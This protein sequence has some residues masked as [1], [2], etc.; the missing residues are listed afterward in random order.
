MIDILRQF[1]LFAKLSDSKLQWWAEHGEESWLE[2]G[3]ILFK[4]GDPAETMFFFVL[5]EGELQ[6]TKQIGGSEVMITYQPG[7]FTGE[8]PILTGKPCGSTVRAVHPS[9]VLQI[10]AE[11]FK[12]LML[13]CS[14]MRDIILPTMMQRLQD[15]EAMLWQRE[16]MAALG[17]LSAG[18]AHELNNPA[19]AGRRAAEQLYETVQSL[20]SLAL[21]L[22]AQAGASVPLD[23][24]TELQQEALQRANTSLRLDPLAQSD[25]EEECSDWLSSSGIQNGWRLAPTLVRAGLNTTWLDSLAARIA[26]Q[27]SNPAPTLHCVLAWLEA[28]LSTVSLLQEIEQSTSRISN[29]VSAVKSYSYMDQASVQEIDVH[30]GLESTMIVLGHRLKQGITVIREYDQSLPRFVAYGDELNQVWTNLIDN[31]ID[32][33]Q[34][35]GQLRIRTA[36]ENHCVLVEIADDGPGVPAEIQSRIFEPFFTTKGVGEGSGL[37]LDISYRIVV[38]RHRGDIRVVS[39]PGDTRFQVRLPLIVQPELNREPMLVSVPSV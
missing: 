29:L 3:A 1:P 30:D 6:L 25:Q 9:R 28:T 27:S 35:R 16:K 26:A 12:S 36:H 20:Q 32:A 38:S 21:N 14:P 4:E 34:G 33:M 23:F 11:S 39:C 7:E 13:N 37:G 8:I 31:A 15:K 19:A 17:K 18:L 2:P 24:F 22:S 5:L 10:S